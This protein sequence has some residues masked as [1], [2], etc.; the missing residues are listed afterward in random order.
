MPNR[1][2]SI[3]GI[4]NKMMS[5]LSSKAQIKTLKQFY[6]STRTSEDRKLLAEKTN[7][8]LANISHWASQ[9][10]LLRVDLMSVDMAYDLIDGG[11]YSVEQLK[12]TDA[13]EIF[14]RVKKENIYSSA[15]VALIQKLQ[16][17]SVREAKAFECASFQKELVDKC[18]STP[19]I[20]TDLSSVITELGRGVAQAQRALDQNSIDIQNE[21]LQNDKLYGMGLQATW[22]VM[23][24]VEFSMKIDYTVSEEKSVTGKPLGTPGISVAP[25]NA[26][27]SN[28]FKSSK[29]EES[30]IKLRIVP[31][32][33]N[34]KFVTRRYMPDLSSLTTVGELK[35]K[36]EENNISTYK[37]VPEDAVGWRDDTK[38]KVLSQSPIRNVILTMDC[39]PSI[40]VKKA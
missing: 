20:Y 35:N 38:I 27:Y 13:K 37:L 2:V 28:L 32:P 31:I 3:A 5:I 21:I 33:A 14:E 9:A 23:P 29:K 40:N 1:L 22:Y 4:D 25:S 17:S 16:S 26:T 12:K 34:D 18:S 24:E 11:I 10:E 30:T 15:T 6:D 8:S 19:S 7:I 39:V 36:L